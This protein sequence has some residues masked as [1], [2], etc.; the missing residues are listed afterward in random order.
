M[1]A[2]EVIPEMEALQDRIKELEGNQN[3]PIPCEHE[4][5]CLMYKDISMDRYKG[6]TRRVHWCWK[7]GCVEFSN[8]GSRSDKTYV[9]GKKPQT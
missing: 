7:C 1:L 5:T 3:N 4:F 6:T 9:P 8:A 2:S